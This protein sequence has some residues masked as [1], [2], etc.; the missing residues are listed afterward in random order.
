IR[1]ETE[2]TGASASLTTTLNEQVAVPAAFD[3]TH[4][5][6]LVPFGNVNGEAILCPFHVQTTVGSGRPDAATGK[7]TKAEHWPRSLFTAMSPG[8][9]VNCGSAKASTCKPKICRAG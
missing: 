7:S 4:D 6:W 5:T 2:A 9:D 8:H 1:W 3:A